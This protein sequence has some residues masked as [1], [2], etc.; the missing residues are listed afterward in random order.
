MAVIT[1]HRK[2]Y[3]VE[4]ICR[5]LPIAPSTYFRRQAQ[6]R[7]PTRRSA[8]AQRDAVLKAI[9]RRIWTE[10]QEVY[11]PRKVWKQIERE[12]DVE[13]ISK[14]W[15]AALDDFRNWLTWAC[16]PRNAMKIS[17]SE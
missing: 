5:V 1:A 13:A 11:G 14:N 10:Q 2:T 6:E 17:A 12:D 8:R 16:G 15:L 9:I 3:G 4:S 7:D